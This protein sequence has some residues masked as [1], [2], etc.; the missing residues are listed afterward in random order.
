MK[1]SRHAL[2]IALLL[3]ACGDGEPDQPQGTTLSATLDVDIRNRAELSLTVKGDV[4]T[5]RINLDKGF[6]VLPAG[7]TLS[8]PGRVERF[9]EADALLY[10]AVFEAP[11]QSGGP[12]G[13]E[14]VSLALALHRT[15]EQAY[16]AGSL[17]PYCGKATLSGAFARNPLR[18]S[19]KLPLAAAP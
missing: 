16:V 2:A 10:T 12:C 13:D 17:T 9:P 11:A 7:Q 15:G 6:A 8:G 18:L 1:R 5:A 14:P 4:L 3:A 19:G